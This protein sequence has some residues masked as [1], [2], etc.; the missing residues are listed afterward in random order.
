MSSGDTDGVDS[1]GALTI[2]GGN[3]SVTGQSAFD[4]DGT[5]TFTGGTVTINGEQVDTIPVQM[6]GGHGGP[7]RRG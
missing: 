1:N 4:V 7:G 5:V 6:M 2:T 3:I